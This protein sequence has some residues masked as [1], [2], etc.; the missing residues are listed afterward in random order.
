[1]E[2]ITAA[3]DLKGTGSGRQR[4]PPPP[5]LGA[6]VRQAGCARPQGAQNSQPRRTCSPIRAL[7]W[8]VT[9]KAPAAA[10]QLT[11][12][13]GQDVAE[14]HPRAVAEDLGLLH[15]RLAHAV[16][17]VEDHHQVVADEEAVDVAVH[18]GQV[19][20]EQLHA[21]ARGIQFSGPCPPV[22]PAL[23]SEERRQQHEAEVAHHGPGR[24]P[25]GD[26]PLR[27]PPQPAP[28]QQRGENEQQQRAARGVQPQQPRRRVQEAQRP[29]G[30]LDG[31]LGQPGGGHGLCARVLSPGLLPLTPGKD[32]QTPVLS[33]NTNCP[34][35][36]GAGRSESGGGRSGLAAPT[37]SS[38][39]PP[40]SDAREETGTHSQPGCGGPPTMG[41]LSGSRP[42]NPGR[43]PPLGRTWL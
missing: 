2:P 18:T 37:A 23:P 3:G 17:V 34:G 16:E 31:G 27:E 9:P 26:A 14:R 22:R 10:A 42:P 32:T 29:R 39:A 8:P 7:T 11:L 13:L 15:Q 20:Q 5:A 40:I 12:P 35:S 30:V 28:A 43:A 24:G 36:P 33:P 1:M 4:R 6:G 38:P 25:G 19:C 21:Q 41:K